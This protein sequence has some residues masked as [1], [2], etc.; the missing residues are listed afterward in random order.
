MTGDAGIPEGF[1]PLD[2]GRPRG[3][4]AADDVAETVAAWFER[5]FNVAP[6]PEQR[7]I[8]RRAYD[9]R[10]GLDDPAG[11]FIDAWSDWTYPERP[12]VDDRDKLRMRQL[13][14]DYH[15]DRLAVGDPYL[16]AVRRA[17]A[18]LAEKTGTPLNLL[19]DP[20]APS[21]VAVRQRRRAIWG[22]RANERRPLVIFDET[23]RM[24]PHGE[25]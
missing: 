4:V 3:P 2:I 11:A 24:G 5:V 23:H 21:D 13:L 20:D 17:V 18:E 6:T 8:I 22:R 16:A 10:P 1:P 14:E 25:H 7:D 12:F 9:D 19:D 15:R